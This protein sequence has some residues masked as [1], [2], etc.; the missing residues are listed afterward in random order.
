MC[1]AILRGD[2]WKPPNKVVD[3]IAKIRGLL[4]APDPDDA[5]EAAIADQLKK[6]PEAFNAA[7]KDFV[8][9]YAQGGA[10]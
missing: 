5:V 10:S 2:E 6:E 8:K 9:K 1:L 7:A 3:V 4:I